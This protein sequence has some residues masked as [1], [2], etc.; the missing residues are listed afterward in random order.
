MRS[1]TCLA[2]WH[3]TLLGPSPKQA[4][5]IQGT[6]HGTREPALPPQTPGRAGGGGPR[7]VHSRGA[8]RMDSHAHLGGGTQQGPLGC[9]RDSLTSYRS[10][11]AV[12]HKSATPSPVTIHCVAL[13]RLPTLPRL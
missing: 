4:L 1:K 12:P 2:W 13:L 8:P 9:P 6:G 10:S 3:R 5:H 7:T 11:M